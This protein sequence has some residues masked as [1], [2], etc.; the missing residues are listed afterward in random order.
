M[1]RNNR[2]APYRPLLVVT[3]LILA[4]LLPGWA[5]AA[6]TRIAASGQAGYR[7]LL[8]FA[9]SPLQTMRP[10]AFTLT[11]QDPTGLETTAPDASCSLVMPAM[12]MPENRPRV[13][14]SGGHF[15]GEAIFTMAGAWQMLVTLR[16]D[17]TEVDHLTFDIER[18]LLQ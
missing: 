7:G 12:A 15:A 14:R 8:E 3:T 18:V 16:R 9:A 1:A 10:T 13:T 6:S 11:L 2:P 4:L 17:G 5:M